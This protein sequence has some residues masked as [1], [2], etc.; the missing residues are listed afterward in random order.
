MRIRTI[1]AVALLALSLA[2]CGNDEEAAS[3]AISKAIMES[4]DESFEVTKEEADC[5]GDGMVDKIGV[6][7]LTEYG[8]ITED[9]ESSGGI[10]NVEMS[11]ADAESAADVMADCADIKQIFTNAM[12]E[13]PEDAQACVDEN[14]DDEVIHEFLVAIFMND[15]EAGQQGVVTALQECMSDGG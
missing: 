15:Q 14:L 5:V 10:E 4:N 6:D 3:E 13:L 1:G 9:L 7:K 8:I 11:E 12:G 2:A